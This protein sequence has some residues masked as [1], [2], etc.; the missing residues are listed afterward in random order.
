[1]DTHFEHGMPRHAAHTELSLPG[2]N[3][4]ASSP[5]QQSNPSAQ[6]SVTHSANHA[7]DGHEGDPSGETAA[8][9][10]TTTPEPT[11]S[12]GRR[13]RLLTGAAI[14][15]LATAA[16]GVFLISPYNH[17]IPV[18]HLASYLPSQ[19]HAAGT[20]QRIDIPAPVT[21]SADLA[22]AQAPEPPPPHPV[23]VASK[24]R[25]AAD[26]QNSDVNIAELLNIRAGSSK[27]IEPDPEHSPAIGVEQDQKP[28][29]PLAVAKPTAVATS[30]AEVIL[31]PSPPAPPPV[32]APAPAAPT[33]SHP[34]VAPMPANPVTVAAA[35]QAAPLSSPQQIEV[36]GLVTELGVLI[37]NQRI[38]NAQL[39][40]DVA[41]MRDRLDTQLSDYD[42][43][44]SLAEARGAISAAMGV[45][46]SPAPLPPVSQSI[47]APPT[48]TVTS[49]AHSLKS[50]ALLT[51]APTETPRRY[52]V[53]AASPGLAM[54]AEVD[55]AGDVGNLLQVSIGDDIPGF[56]KVKSITQ[57]GAAWVLT[58]ERGTIR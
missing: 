56:G 21:P 53:Q 41:Q 3:D 39:K 33:V 14:V 58:A 47:N 34:A 16:A 26:A 52:R 9:A 20:E 6:P 37:R 54:L 5:D 31:P 35:L 24:P 48:I 36:L 46:I 17:F 42:R 1:M 44:L 55:R 51:T 38:E 19:P 43:R 57:Q 10:E 11:A 22:R 7:T 30:Q 15:V 29:L 40:L 45:G 8:T 27:G 25:L 32:A 18:D 23:V 50:G 13:S 4:P 2:E 49:P 28:I 12:H